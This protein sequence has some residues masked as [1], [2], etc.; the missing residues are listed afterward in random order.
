MR[1]IHVLPNLMPR[2]SVTTPSVEQQ[3]K[4]ILAE[5]ISKRPLPKPVSTQRVQEREVQTEQNKVDAQTDP[6]PDNLMNELMNRYLEIVENAKHLLNMNHIRWNRDLKIRGSDAPV[7][8]VIE[9]IA[10]HMLANDD[11]ISQQL[12]AGGREQPERKMRK[13]RGFYHEAF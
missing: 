1:K 11:V 12:L 10:A 13:G 3:L 6:G 4:Q 9:N 2:Q 5:I 7:I 8:L